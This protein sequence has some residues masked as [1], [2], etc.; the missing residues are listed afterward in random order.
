MLRAW[1]H[2]RGILAT[3]VMDPGRPGNL[4]IDPLRTL[5]GYAYRP[6]GSW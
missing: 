5:P 2:S 4:A 6:G 3:V 1:L